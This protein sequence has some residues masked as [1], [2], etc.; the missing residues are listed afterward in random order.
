MAESRHVQNFE[1]SAQG[2]NATVNTN[3][4]VVVCPTTSTSGL[5]SSSS[6]R[7]INY[8]NQGTSLLTPA[9]QEFVYPFHRIV[10]A[11]LE[12]TNASAGPNNIQFTTHNGEWGI[13]RLYV[14]GREDATNTYGSWQGVGDFLNPTA[15][16]SNTNQTITTISG[17]PAG[18]GSPTVTANGNTLQVSV[19]GAAATTIRWRIVFEVYCCDFTQ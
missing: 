3:H 11:E 18:W 17:V 19:V 14:I 6:T 1:S 8:N 13:W 4:S 12:S 7:V 5:F 9:G 16:A 15:G 10:T 2:R